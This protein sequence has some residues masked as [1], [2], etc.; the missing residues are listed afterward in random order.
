MASLEASFEKACQ[1]GTIPGAV[2]MASD[3]TGKHP[4]SRPKNAFCAIPNHTFDH[5]ANSIG[6]FNYA[7]AFGVRSLAT[8]QPMTLDTIMFTASCTKLLTTIAALQCVER[9]LVTLD[10]DTSARLPELGS[11]KILTGFD[12]AGEPVLLDRKN[13]ITLR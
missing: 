7:Q 13:P 11:Q 9:G 3:R 6:A 4:I 12:E 1:D 10:E 2:L 8:K 5:C